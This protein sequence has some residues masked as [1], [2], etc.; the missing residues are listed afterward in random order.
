M[1]RDNIRFT[2]TGCSARE[3]PSVS[4]AA[5]PYKIV[6]SAVSPS[7]RYEVTCHT[8]YLVT[9]DGYDACVANSSVDVS[10]LAC[11]AAAF[12]AGAVL[13]EPRDLMRRSDRSARDVNCALAAMC[14][15]HPE[16]IR[17]SSSKTGLWRSRAS[18]W[19]AGTS[20]HAWEW[21]WLVRRL[22]GGVCLWSEGQFAS[23]SELWSRCSSG[24]WVIACFLTIEWLV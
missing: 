8:V 23:C 4:R 14:Q 21:I 17:P 22:R 6:N 20:P 5:Q 2:P 1:G 15:H 24:C 18:P 12:D 3:D 7:R 11:L 9:W 10:I 13:V 19:L 16:V